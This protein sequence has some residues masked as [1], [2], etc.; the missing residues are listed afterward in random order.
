MDR[1]MASIALADNG[2]L[3]LALRDTSIAGAAL[4]SD[5]D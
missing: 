4:G 5:T 3:I 1:L 2:T